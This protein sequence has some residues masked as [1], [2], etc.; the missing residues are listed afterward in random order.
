MHL[1]QFINTVLIL[2]KEAGSKESNRFTAN[3][4]EHRT[5]S[6]HTAVQKILKGK[7][8]LFIFLFI[9]DNSYAMTTLA[10][11]HV[12]QKSMLRIDNIFV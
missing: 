4:T 5:D 3:R 2:C 10:A 9:D 12:R 6:T 7:N 1:T 11:R 8:G